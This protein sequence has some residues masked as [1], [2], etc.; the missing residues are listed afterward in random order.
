M[1]N[2][3]FLG[4]VGLVL[5]FPS[6]SSDDNASP[7]NGFNYNGSFYETK[8]L[9][10]NYVDDSALGS[11][12]SVIM[13]NKDLIESCESSNLNYVLMQFATN[14][15][16]VVLEEVT[17]SDDEYDFFDYVV[18]NDGSLDSSCDIIDAKMILFDAMD[19]FWAS[20][21]S[22]TIN[23]FNDNNIDLSFSFTREDGAV[24]NGNYSG[25]Y[26]DVSDL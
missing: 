2:L 13:V 9:Y 8:D 5:L 23:T 19:D 18:F 11:S 25:S 16:D 12:I 3:I 7:Q 1:K 4:L 21:I 24:I 14:S 10:L 6:C 26:T 20:P 17:Y 22:L 15:P